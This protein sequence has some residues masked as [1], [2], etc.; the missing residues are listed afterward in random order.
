MCAVLESALVGPGPAP[1]DGPD[2]PGN[3]RLSPAPSQAMGRARTAALKPPGGTPSPG[4]DSA[5]ALK[6]KPAGLRS[7]LLL[8]LLRYDIHDF[9]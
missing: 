2:P 5:S 7:R 8:G 4:W 3:A 9:A 6:L 1:R